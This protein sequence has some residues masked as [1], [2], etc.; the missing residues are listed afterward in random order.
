MKCNNCN[1]EFPNDFEICPGCGTKAP[2][3]TINK[4]PEPVK[5]SPKKKLKLLIFIMLAV[6]VVLVVVALLIDKDNKSDVEISQTSSTLESS[7]QTTVE[8]YDKLDFSALLITL[9]NYSEDINNAFICDSDSDGRVEL[10]A[11]TSPK[12]IYKKNTVFSFETADTKQMSS[13]THN[14]AAGEALLKK[15]E[16]GSA[17]LVWGYHSLGTSSDTYERYTTEG[18]KSFATSS[19]DYTSSS[20]EEFTPYEQTFEGQITDY[21]TWKSKINDLG[22]IDYDEGYRKLYSNYFICDN[23]DEVI[24]NYRTH[25]NQSDYENHLFAEGDFDNDGKTEY[26]FV[27]E[28][29]AYPWVQNLTTGGTD[30]K[31][32][33]SSLEGISDFGTVLIY[34]DVDDKGI[35]FNTFYTDDFGSADSIKVTAENCSLNLCSVDA[36]GNK[37]AEKSF[38]CAP[39]EKASYR[40]GGE[41]LDSIIA[42]FKNVENKVTGIPCFSTKCDVS[43]NPG[44]E[45]LL[46]SLADT[47]PEKLV[48]YS[49][50]CGRVIEIDEFKTDG[51]ATLIATHNSLEAILGYSQ[52]EVNEI[53]NGV[54]TKNENTYSYTLTRYD[55]N[56]HLI[57]LEEDTIL[58]DK[59]SSTGTDDILKLEGLSE[60][61]STCSACYDPYELTGNKYMSSADINV[62]GNHLYIS[63]C[64][65]SKIGFVN[66]TDD[67]LNFREGPG[68]SYPKKLTNNID[69]TSFVKQAD[70]SPV[71]VFEIVN[72]TDTQY[73]IWFKI[74]IKYRNNTLI[75]YS[76]QKY[77]KVP[78]IT[79]LKIGDK[80]TVIADASENDLTWSSSDNTILTIDAKTGETT[81]LKKG[82]VIVSVKSPSGLTSSCIIEVSE[83]DDLATQ[84]ASTTSVAPVSNTKYPTVT[85]PLQVIENYQ[86]IENSGCC[87]QIE[88]LN[89]DYRNNSEMMEHIPEK[90][91]MMEYRVCKITC[92]YCKNGN[93]IVEHIYHYADKSIVDYTISQD[94]IFTMNGE[95][96]IIELIG[97]GSISYDKSSAATSYG[98]NG[99]TYVHIDLLNSGDMP[100]ERIRFTLKSIDGTL[101]IVDKE[102][103]KTYY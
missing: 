98:D 7:A 55:V 14:G 93:D 81:A 63:N 25:L 29:F 19:G 95:L 90:Y 30:G 69:N 50:F 32:M 24:N 101:K 38:F 49:V 100:V 51:R 2:N 68:V 41:L 45:F 54:V 71:T 78:N 26:A 39:V 31:L 27:L 40:Y 16:D 20:A 34:A 67:W 59:T 36:S 74:Q 87:C 80:F 47:K 11:A 58:I 89:N 75:G 15:S 91:K 102:I 92:P 66:I 33:L 57:T 17:V 99:E 46:L 96:Y 64:S 53:V 84:N 8:L 73:P 62:N 70:N 72:T 103:E 5:E 82:M 48:L 21:T 85:D 88:A 22:I 1:T 77:I 42:D 6:V 10:F 94:C 35:L 76:A 60:I 37:I 61:L 44:Q 52:D 9:D 13:T 18:W 3:S 83:G 65:T 43:D 23:T 4:D 79:K 86:A 12:V 28:N 97:A 56:F